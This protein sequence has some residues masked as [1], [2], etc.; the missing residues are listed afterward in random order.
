VT[1]VDTS[2]WVEHFRKGDR[3]LQDL[4]ANAKAIVHP[5][6]IGE[7]ACGNLKNRAEI[8]HLLSELPQSIV[9]DQGE[10]LKLVESK[11]LFGTGLGWI[12]AHL[13]ASALLSDVTMI[14]YDKAVLEAASR[15][16]IEYR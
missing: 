16:R 1:L 6:I 2:V 11:K 5:F 12:D 15:L 13:L 4:L 3:T 9:A 14:S 8:L 7:L 10:V